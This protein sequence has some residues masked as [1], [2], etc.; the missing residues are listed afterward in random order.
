MTR[1]RIL[2]GLVL[3][4]ATTASAQSLPPI[5][6]S[7]A[8]AQRAVDATNAHTA[9]MTAEP[10]TALEAQR[11]AG[12]S[13]RTS[14]GARAT[15]SAAGSAAIPS[16][17]D[18]ARPDTVFRREVFNYASSGRRDPFV[19]LMANG[20]LMPVI[21]DLQVKGILYDAKHGNSVAMLIDA[22][23]K[24]EYRV[25]TGMTLGRM[26]VARIGEKSVT[27]TI[28]EFGYSRQETLALSDPTKEKGQ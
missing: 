16:S 2:L 22:S 17:A 19:S 28:E 13:G 8:T 10:K 15:G 14:E 20:E 7:K 11:A 5:T 25:K 3:L 21:T 24:E 27:F 1:M 6:K 4:G 18:D 9:A 12:D 26:R 23:T